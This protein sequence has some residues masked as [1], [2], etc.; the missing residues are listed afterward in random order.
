MAQF[1]FST[2]TKI[3]DPLSPFI[4]PPDTQA[5]DYRKQTGILF[6]ALQDRKMQEQ[7]AM[8]RKVLEGDQKIKGKAFD[9]MTRTDGPLGKFA[10]L[11]P[12]LDKG[13]L[14][15]ISSRSNIA[16]NLKAL[17]Q[18]NKM[19]IAGIGSTNPDKTLAAAIDIGGGK[20]IIKKLPL[21]F[22]TAIAGKPDTTIKT[23]RSTVKDGRTVAETHETR[24]PSISLKRLDDWVRNRGPQQQAQAQAQG[25]RP[26]PQMAE[27]SVNNVLN[28]LPGISMDQNDPITVGERNGVLVITGGHIYVTKKGKLERK[29][30]TPGMPVKEWSNAIQK[31]KSLSG[32]K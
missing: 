31:H 13:M 20:N 32:I 18:L 27:S 5:E 8:K 4:R 28:S 11:F 25:S 19:N 26:T 3:D 16:N 14:E 15:Q 23:K 7:A 9:V 1:G 21:A 6:G 29:R 10:P 22:V 2:S 24:I 30:V 17:D 12:W